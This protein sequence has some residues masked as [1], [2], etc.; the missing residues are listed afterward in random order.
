MSQDFTLEPIGVEEKEIVVTAQA[1]GQNAAINQQLSSDKIIN[2][3][4]AAKIEALPDA[5]AAESVGSLPGISLIREGGEGSQVVIR[6]LSPK[7][8]EVTI[9]GV[10]IPGNVAT[11]DPTA[12]YEGYGQSVDLSMISSSMLGGIEVTKAITPDMDAA[13]LG[14]VVNFDLREAKTNKG[15]PI[16]NLKAQGGYNGLRSSVSNYKFVA[17]GEQRFLSDR[18]GIFAQATAEK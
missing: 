15:V 1:S 10:R 12:Q 5:N 8:N 16:F 17:S 6:G 13:V 18:L 2:V 11:N 7:Y 4:S 9:D 3:V 14:G